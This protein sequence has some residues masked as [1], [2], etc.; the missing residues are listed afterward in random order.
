MRPVRVIGLDQGD[1]I[2]GYD[3]LYIQIMGTNIHGTIEYEGTIDTAH[4][5]MKE[6]TNNDIPLYSFTPR[7]MTLED[8]YLQ[9]YKEE[10][11]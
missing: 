10:I 2:K 8:L 1:P 11:Q 6:I 3:K 4:T 7:A 9:L 5:I